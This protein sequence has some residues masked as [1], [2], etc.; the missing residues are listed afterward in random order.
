M[1]NQLSTGEQF[2]NWTVLSF[3]GTNKKHEQ[4]YNCQCICGTIRTVRKGNLGVAIGCGCV[5]KTYKVQPKIRKQAKKA[6]STSPSKVNKLP[7]D[8][9]V[10]RPAVISL[11]RKLEEIR[12]KREL[13]NEYSLESYL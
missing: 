6:K 4:L 1:K 9:A 12:L 13:E 8:T 11:D 7:N 2:N 3:A 10:R 5:R